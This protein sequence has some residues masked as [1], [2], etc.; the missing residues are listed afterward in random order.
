MEEH[1]K[2]EQ[3]MRDALMK[4]QQPDA[5]VTDKLMFYTPQYGKV[6]TFEVNEEELTPQKMKEIMSYQIEIEK[7]EREIQEKEDLQQEKFQEQIKKRLKKEKGEY[8]IE[9]NWDEYESD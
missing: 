9:E 1:L 5:V 7:V 6:D 4:A 8:D 2:R 3:E